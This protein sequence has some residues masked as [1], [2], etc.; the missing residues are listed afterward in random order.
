MFAGGYCRLAIAHDINCDIAFTAIARLLRC[1]DLPCMRNRFYY[2]ILAVI[3]ASNIKFEIRFLNFE[4][5]VMVSGLEHYQVV[6][7]L[8]QMD[9][10]TGRVRP[11]KVMQDVPIRDPLTQRVGSPH[12]CKTS[13][14]CSSFRSSYCSGGGARKNL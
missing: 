13:L 11:L 4:R 7:D 3:A 8:S 2:C 14:L 12:L 1:L 10:A 5:Q 9:D 6:G